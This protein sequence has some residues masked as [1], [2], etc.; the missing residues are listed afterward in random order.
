M[1][2]HTPW[3]WLAT[4]PLTLVLAACP[5]GDDPAPGVDAGSDGGPHTN[6]V[7]C[8][9]LEMSKAAVTVYVD[10]SASGVEAGTKQAPYKTLATAFANAGSNG[11]IWVA[12]G[13]YRENLVV[14][15]KDL[16]VEGGFASGFGSRTDGCATVVE[17][18]N[19]S[20]PVFAA[21]GDVKSFAL[22]GLT[23]RKGAHGLLVEGDASV[24]ATFRITSAVF[25]E[26]GQVDTAGGG[27]SFENVSASVSRSVFIDNQASKG[28][29]LALDNGLELSI[30]DSLFEHN[31]GHS[32]HGGA[33]Y[34][35]PSHGTIRGNTFR[36][37]EIGRDL[38]Y[39]WG[40]AVIVYQGGATPVTVDL[41]YNVFTDNL[42]SVG[43]AVFVDDG[44][45]I[46]MSHDLLYRNRSLREN[47]VVRGAAL[48]ADGA[49]PG[50][51]SVLKAD[52]VTVV[53]NV[54]DEAG[55]RGEITQGGAVYA[56][57]SSKVEF[58]NSILWNN[59]KDALFGD[60]T[61]EITVS[62]SVAPGG[63]IGARCTIG[64]GVFEPAD[65]LFVDEAA[66]DYHAKSTA[67]HFHDGSWVLDT[68]TSPTIDR[69]DPADAVSDEPAP[70]G[71][72][73]NLGAY[74]NTGEASK[75]P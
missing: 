17:A 13:Q 54:Y 75:S 61:T 25:V 63:C 24:Q 69:A 53:D 16:V 26:N 15:A 1:K 66:D 10:A 21:S 20:L 73:G 46:T 65:V 72:R 22:E 39:G 70:N 55:N 30:E 7:I 12:A 3:C 47:G 40:G 14:P 50:I 9:P 62:Y 48:Y 38:G 60:P 71:N 31:I 11:V 32:D 18:A 36:G 42:A 45:T 68:V 4:V 33:V 44:A 35:G 58:T 5:A 67:G 41:S 23:I 57:T 34:T 6:D 19:P 28:A 51:G 52:H 27:A 2:P 29:A 64:T 8:P 49:S 43:G 37:N 59:G 56:E 74:G